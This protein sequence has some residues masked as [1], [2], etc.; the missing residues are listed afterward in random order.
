M[1][2]QSS[3][4]TIISTV[5]S[6]MFGLFCFGLLPMVA[7]AN[8]KYDV[9]QD[10]FKCPECDLSQCKNPVGCELVKEP[11]VCGCCMTC[12]KAEGESCG[13]STEQCG[14]GLRCNP[15]E[16]A[17]DG[18]DMLLQGGGICQPVEGLSVFVKSN[19]RVLQ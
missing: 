14:T 13:I 3:Q 2:L 10:F 8:P 15:P 18:F 6:I 19:E 16:N 5:C 9:Y 17:I 11:G 4:C 7:Q 1:A 12:A